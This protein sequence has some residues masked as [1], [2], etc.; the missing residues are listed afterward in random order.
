ME[1]EKKPSLIIGDPSNISGC[2][3][4]GRVFGHS[5]P[6][7]RRHMDTLGVTMDPWRH[8]CSPSSIHLCGPA[9][10]LLSILFYDS[11]DTV[12]W[13]ERMDVMSVRRWDNPI[14]LYVYPI[15]SRTCPSRA[16]KKKKTILYRVH[17]SVALWLWVSTTIYNMTPPQSL[18]GSAG[19]RAG[20]RTS[21]NSDNV[22]CCI[23]YGVLRTMD[24]LHSPHVSISPCPCCMMHR[25]CFYFHRGDCRSYHFR[26][27]LDATAPRLCSSSS[28]IVEIII[29]CWGQWGDLAVLGLPLLGNFLPVGRVTIQYVIKN[30]WF[31]VYT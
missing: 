12:L 16:K 28:M 17:V 19:I 15:P 23:A 30:R 5:S 7:G 9:S 26:P 13:L 11:R 14:T 10:P 22:H 18:Q 6:A 31:V 2:S 8:G 29:R 3:L 25:R 21:P 24:P 20:L 27:P 1:H 4:E